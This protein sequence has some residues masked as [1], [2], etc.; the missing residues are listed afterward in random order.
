MQIV[1]A[2]GNAHKVAEISAILA[3]HGIEILSAETR[4]GMP[5]VIEDGLTFKENAVKK[6]TT[7]A[8]IWKCPVIADDSGLEVVALNG[9]PGVFSARYA[10]EGGNDGRN[11]K[12]LLKNMEGVSDRRARFVTVIALALPDGTVRTAEG[13][14]KGTIIHEARGTGGFGYDPAFVPDDF[15][16]TFA[17][18]PAETKN[19]LSHR[20]NALKNALEKG[21]FVFSKN[22]FKK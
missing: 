14:V 10:G 8:K 7:C 17:E 2:T 11:L 6:A 15:D 13:T 1:V 12:K 3:P 19:A 5:E 9:A 22:D 4:G 16:K 18:L 20:A 21:L